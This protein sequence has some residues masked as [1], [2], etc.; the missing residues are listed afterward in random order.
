MSDPY[1]VINVRYPTSPQDPGHVN[2]TFHD[3]QGNS[4]T[5]GATSRGQLGQDHAYH[6]GLGGTLGGIG[7]NFSGTGDGVIHVELPANWDGQSLSVSS[8][9]GYNSPPI[10]LN[11]AAFSAFHGFLVNGANGQPGLGSD[12]TV[13]SNASIVI[14]YD[15]GIQGLDIHNPLGLPNGAGSVQQ[16]ASVAAVLYP[17]GGVLPGFV[18]AYWLN[19]RNGFNCLE[20]IFG[21]QAVGLPRLFDPNTFDFGEHVPLNALMPRE[22]IGLDW[23]SVSVGVYGLQHY[24][25]IYLFD[26]SRVQIPSIIVRNNTAYQVQMPW[27]WQ[28]DVRQLFFDAINQ[29][30]ANRGPVDAQFIAQIYNQINA[31]LAFPP[32]NGV[33][34]TSGGN[35]PPTAHLRMA[36]I[37]AEARRNLGPSVITFE[38]FEHC[39]LAGTKV[40]MADGSERAIET[41]KIGDEV[42]AFDGSQQA[43]R[44]PLVSGKVVRVFISEKSNLINV[45][46]LMVTEEHPFLTDLGS[47]APIGMFPPNGHVVSADGSLSRVGVI[48]RIP[49]TH[50][51]YNFEVEGLHTYVAG[52]IRV[53]NFSYLT[54][55]SE[56]VWRYFRFGEGGLPDTVSTYDAGSGSLD[57]W[58]Q[59]IGNGTWIRNQF[60]AGDLIQAIYANTGQFSPEAFGLTPGQPIGSINFEELMTSPALSQGIIFDSD[61]NRRIE[62]GGDIAFQ[63]GST[64]GR[65]LSDDPFGQLVLGVALGT[66]A[67]N[68]GEAIANGGFT[69]NWA[70]HVDS[71]VFDD[72]FPELAGA[73]AG[74]VSSVLVGEL[75]DALGL[76]GELADLGQSLVNGYVSR[77]AEN[78]I[79]PDTA[80][81]DGLEGVN[82]A[83]IVASFIGARLAAELIE[84]DTIGG[85]VGAS[86]GSSVGSIIGI[87][88]GADG[89]LLG[90]EIGKWAG[91]IGALAGAFVG[92]ILGGLIGSLFGGTPKG[93]AELAWN[94]H[95]QSFDVGRV[96]SKNGGSKDVVGSMAGQVGQILNGMIAAMGSRVADASGIRAGAYEIKGK[97]YWY[98]EDGSSPISFTTRDAE[99]LVLHGAYVALTD[100]SERLVGGDVYVKRALAATLAEASGAT[101]N[102]TGNALGGLAGARELLGGSAPANPAIGAFS[103]DL[104]FGNISTAQD[105]A[106]Y[107]QNAPVITALIS[108]SP[109]SAFAAGWAITRAR[110]LELGLDRRWRS[111]WL[112]GW[113]AFLDQAEDGLV[114]GESITPG[115]V[116]LELDP[117]SR[118]RSFVFLDPT[119]ALRTVLGDTIETTAKT[120]VNAT[121]TDDAI[122]LINDTWTEIRTI[123]ETVTVGANRTFFN[124]R[125]NSEFTIDSET[126]YQGTPISLG[127]GLVLTGETTVEVTRDVA[128]NH[129]GWRVAN[130]AGL[131]IDGEA[132]TSGPSEQI[133]V[134]AVIDGGAGNDTIRGGDLGNDLLGGDGNDTLIGGVLDDWQF[135][136]AGDDRLFAGD[137]ADVSFS[138][139]AT[140][141]ASQA[142]RDAAVVVD[143][144]NG[145]YLD[146]GE[147]NDFIYGGRGSD[148]LNGGAGVD[149][150]IGGDG[151]DILDGGAGD[152]RGA[153][154]EAF[155]LGGAGSDQYVF[156]YGAGH[157]VIFDS[158][159]ATAVAGAGLY[160]A[161]THYAFLGQNPG[162]RNW[163]GG[164]D[165]EVDGSVVGGEDAI[166]FGS[167]IGFEDISLQRGATNGVANA[168]LIIDL[169]ALDT[170]GNRVLTGDSL[171]IRDWFDDTRK[172]EWL[173]F[174]DGQDIRIGDLSSIIIGPNVGDSIIGT[175][176]NDWAVGTSD[177]DDFSLLNGDDFGFGGKGDDF[178]GGDGDNDFLSGGDDND[179]VRGGAGHDTAFGDAGNDTVE[180][181]EG[182]D[183]VVGGR[184]NDRVVGGAGNDLYRFSRGDGQDVVLDDYAAN[185][186]TEIIFNAGDSVNDYERTQD[187]RAMR[188]AM[189]GVIDDNFWNLPV[190]WDGATGTLRERTGSVTVSNAGLDTFEFGYG[191]DIEDIQLA[192]IGGDLV[193]AIADG[194]FDASAF[195]DIADRITFESW[196]AV[197]G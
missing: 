80:I 152:D 20:L 154:G 142:A 71:N 60:V 17:E 10:P 75:F 46:G 35:T 37:T 189:N 89:V 129:T 34:F 184:G 1:M 72:F 26:V 195:M 148:W 178:V 13:V 68:V 54:E 101:P 92:Y 106:Q 53:H 39:F 103:F 64:L 94:A 97:K 42:A 83:T 126:H 32:E 121:S 70:V 158:G 155:L 58:V 96:W 180:G 16:W 104:L 171:T 144:G 156:Y 151:G 93:G 18:G 67:R 161:N 197:P 172:V 182:N 33:M 191:I 165:Y 73:A 85:Q 131:A 162:A 166:S 21:N 65:L 113:G 181:N 193:M 137:V 84:F 127:E 185:T 99:S 136:G 28:S 114:D 174:A 111:D 134:A 123:T 50:R 133:R 145:D 4:F 87:K 22:G 23:L 88:A 3:G 196:I 135:G 164:G 175:N 45:A 122:A 44:G 118:G 115:T 187:W 105:Y 130:A 86:L 170:N 138:D 149:R 55:I 188:V 24:S 74:A 62:F 140:D 109:Q 36:G 40:L 194:S 141:A 119:G 38:P 116:L 19:G 128:I 29:R 169:T 9:L 183:I 69:I 110:V 61:L 79:T 179:F 56:G 176:G 57:V 14:D 100:L 90:F 150:L 30:L 153:N 48:E 108:I 95:S 173:R 146:G 6:Q 190:M 15:L 125:T 52:G 132:I 78:L 27:S 25:D 157:D 192:R 143:G 186:T 102:Y 168:D 163:A 98:K 91:P 8:V 66:L 139:T 147:G 82:P 12:L 43:G 63:F 76:E 51:V 107:I 31:Q 47:F 167:G 77:I 160:S 11:P 159:N 2:Y 117:Q 41:I 112:G 177:A 49:G 120:L 7:A 124:R 5:I 81:F 59:D